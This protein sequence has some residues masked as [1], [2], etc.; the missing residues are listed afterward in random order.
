LYPERSKADAGRGIAPDWL[1]QD[2]SGWNPRKLLL[3]GI[4]MLLP[5]NN[6]HPLSRDKVRNP[7][8]AFLKHG[9]AS[10]DIKQLLWGSCP[11]P[12]PES[13]ALSA[14][15]NYAIHMVLLLSHTWMIDL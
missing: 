11:A 7:R 14:G 3:H 2:I 12:G 5:G 4:C 6:D 9:P 10:P 8:H 1:D 13:G 15:H